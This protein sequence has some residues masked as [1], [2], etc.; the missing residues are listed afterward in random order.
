[1]TAI[2]TPIPA[3]RDPL[4][5]PKLMVLL[6]LAL[7]LCF[8]LFV[9]VSNDEAYYWLWG[10]RPALSYFDHPPLHAWL[11]GLVSLPLGW[12]L[13]SLRFSTW[14][15]TAL[16]AWVFWRWTERLA[17]HD[18]A[19]F[20]WYGAAI[21]LASPVMTA[22]STL[23][24]ND[25]LMLALCLA[26][27]WCFT[28]FTVRY[29][30]GETRPR[31]LY[32]SALLLG[33]AVLAK[34]NAVFLAAGYLIAALWRPGLRPLLAN[35]HAWAAGGLAVL[36]QLPVLVWA[37]QTDF[38][39]FRFHLAERGVGDHG[40]AGISLVRGLRYLL[41]QLFWLSP[42]LWW[43]VLRYAFSRPADPTAAQR[44]AIAVATLAV[45]S[46]VMAALSL[47]IRVLPYWTDVGYLLPLL[48]A[49]ALVGRR[50]L[51]WAHMLLGLG[52]GAVIL[53]N[54]AVIPVGT[55]FGQND[56]GSAV[57]YGWPE[58]EAA[59]R[60]AEAAHPDAFLAATNYKLAAPL[61]Y[62]LHTT[63]IA[64]LSDRRD[65]FDYWFEEAA[66]V[67]R[68]GLVLADPIFPIA[69]A[70]P[71]FETLTLVAEVPV[72]R[73]GHTIHRFLIYLGTGYIPPAQP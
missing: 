17:P 63:D 24:F 29:E 15:T 35:P 4:L 65:Q 72:V 11:Q 21:Y 30:A 26:S 5:A 39:S 73:F 18:R 42:F 53:V 3:R 44:R 40:P 6:F 14:L 10:Q 54:Y 25:H 19:G 31:W 61:G 20:F 60:Q 22:M 45:S 47:S 34:Y 62:A 8:D 58:V 55:L 1:M 59:M 70:E 23:A 52:F 46:L 57:L 36:I 16:G 27:A 48:L 37:I 68:P 49:V 33:L 41:W 2:S 51:F 12:N 43:P 66:A 7:R 13:V 67:G 38:A 56:Y 69:T 71:R 28:E 32:A 9:P 50:L 64:T